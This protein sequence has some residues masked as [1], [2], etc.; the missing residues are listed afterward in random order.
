[1][2]ILEK[3]TFHFGSTQI[4][5]VRFQYLEKH[6]AQKQIMAKYTTLKKWIVIKNEKEVVGKTDAAPTQTNAKQFL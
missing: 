5:F 3:V 6:F 2:K 4:D 1:M